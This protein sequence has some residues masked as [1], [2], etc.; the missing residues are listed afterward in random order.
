MRVTV[1]RLCP[2]T[3]ALTPASTPTPRFDRKYNTPQVATPPS[4]IAAA[5]NTIATTSRPSW[6]TLASA[7]HIDAMLDCCGG[8]G[9]RA[10][11]D[12]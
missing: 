11:A 9:M 12:A 7:F 8:S 10:R 5:P 2:T 6:R 1:A 3:Y 4:T